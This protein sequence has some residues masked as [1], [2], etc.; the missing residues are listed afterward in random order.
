MALPADPKQRKQF[1]KRFYNTLELKPLEA[2]DPA[3]VEGLHTIAGGVDPLLELYKQID[4]SESAA[5]FLFTGQR[6]TGKSTELRRLQR[7]LEELGCAVFL[8]D[9]EDYLN[10]AAPVELSDFLLAVMAGFAEAAGKRLGGDHLARGWMARV[11]SYFK[12]TNVEFT[13]VA[14]GLAGLTLA[15]VHNPT[16]KERLQERARAHV[17]ALGQAA[18]EFA[19]EVVANVRKSVGSESCKVV[20]LVDSMERLRGPSVS[21]AHEVYDSVDYLFNAH[22]DKLRFDTL[23]VVYSI[24]P[25]LPILSPNIGALYGVAAIPMLAGIRVRAR[26]AAESTDTALAAM[27]S[28]VRRRFPEAGEL[29][30]DDVLNRI[31]RSSG[32]DIRDY[33]RLLRICLTGIALEASELRIDQRQVEYA[34]AAVRR[35]MS[36]IPLDE[37]DWL[38]EIRSTQKVRLPQRS[39]LHQLALFFETKLILHYRNGDDWFDVHPLIDSLVDRHGRE[40]RQLA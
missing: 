21:K 15:L 8:V 9:L 37:L 25:Y 6:G 3:Y 1:L 18:R 33:F 32:G 29:I 11:T 13:G 39:R 28:L 31:A 26:A 36:I 10:L 35:D 34:E 40:R 24:P 19:D 27:R 22:A 12:E 17:D 5:P 20:L 23:H 4:W 14:D 16:F 30:D 38:H 7:M 2:G